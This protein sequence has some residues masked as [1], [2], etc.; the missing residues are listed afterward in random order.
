MNFLSFVISKTF[1]FQAIIALIVTVAL[2]F[3]ALK[4]IEASTK[5]GESIEVPDLSKMQ[6]DEAQDELALQH[7]RLEVLDS[8]NYNPDYPRFSVIEQNPVPGKRVKEKRKIYVKINPSGYQKI[9]IPNLIRHTKRQVIP[10]LEILGFKVGDTTYKP[11]IAK[12]AVL[13]MSVKGKK[14]KPGDMIKKTSTIDL[15]LGDGKP[16]RNKKKKDTVKDSKWDDAPE[17]EN[18][19]SDLDF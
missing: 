1:W 14:I 15:V 11:D 16:K 17:L 18:D 19:S 13:E 12:D 7:L 9:E 10:T 4:W 3:L 2:G 6:V 8:V 5:H